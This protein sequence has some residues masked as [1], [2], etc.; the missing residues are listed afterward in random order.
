MIKCPHC[1]E[2]FN[3][4]KNSRPTVNGSQIWRRR[5]CRRCGKTFT[6]Y[7]RILPN[8]LIVVKQGGHKERYHRSKLY[9]GIYQASLKI[10]NKHEAVDKV[11]DIIESRLFD[12][13]KKE[14]GSREIA[15][16]TLE[17]LRESNIQTFLRYLAHNK[18]PK[19]EAELSKLLRKYKGL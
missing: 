18:K 19:D 12:L 8:F 6:T 15:D 9:V 7:E 13:E 17:V 14:I 1:R 2:D 10:P 16:I 4:V 11:V 3:D 5:F